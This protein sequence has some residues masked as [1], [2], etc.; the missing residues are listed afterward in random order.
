MAVGILG[1]IGLLD[2]VVVP[3]LFFK[4]AKYG[5]S[6]ATAMIEHVPPRSV[7]TAAR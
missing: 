7:P 4:Y 5:A 1:G 3:A 6:R 2:M